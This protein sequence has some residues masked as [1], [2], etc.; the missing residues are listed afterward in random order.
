MRSK[1]KSAR[2]YHRQLEPDSI[3]LERNGKIT[4][5][6]QLNYRCESKQGRQALFL[7]R[8]SEMLTLIRFSARFVEWMCEDGFARGN[9]L[10]RSPRWLESINLPARG[11]AKP[12][13]AETREIETSCRRA[14][15]RSS[16][17]RAE[18]E[19]F[20]LS[21]TALEGAGIGSLFL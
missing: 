6:R 9:K 13:G 12:I 4:K 17:R 2:A 11:K 16:A 5:A 18:I 21:M 20:S 1:G 7:P 8:A 3:P 19:L 10:D 14:R 15:K